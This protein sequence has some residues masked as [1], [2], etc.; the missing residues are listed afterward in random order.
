M[1]TKA[2]NVCI[3]CGKKRIVART[4]KEYVG[5]TLV[6]YTDMVC[7]DPECQK[8]VDEISAARKEKSDFLKRKR[9]K[10]VSSKV[11]KK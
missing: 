2:Q 1:Q 3:K 5:L 8:L 7:P 6:T 4:Y 10:N 11:S 9:E